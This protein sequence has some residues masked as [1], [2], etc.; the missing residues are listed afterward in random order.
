MLFNLQDSEAL[1]NEIEF[2]TSTG[3]TYRYTF[4]VEEP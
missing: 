1:S 3:E 2:T 4:A